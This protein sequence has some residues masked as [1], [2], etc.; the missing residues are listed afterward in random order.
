[1][2]PRTSSAPRVCDDKVGW[3]AKATSAAKEDAEAVA[4]QNAVEEKE[5]ADKEKEDAVTKAAH[6]AVKEKQSADK[7]K[8]DV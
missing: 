8:E 4:A 3:A 6:K 1:M 7:E 5:R 2:P